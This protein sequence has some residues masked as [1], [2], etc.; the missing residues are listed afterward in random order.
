MA[1]SN[2]ERQKL[3][4]QKLKAQIA[5]P[6]RN[7]DELIE[8]IFRAYHSAYCRLHNPSFSNCMHYQEGVQSFRR[9][10]E[11]EL[12]INLGPWREPGKSS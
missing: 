9:S 8:A 3:H 12:G 2:A 1:L 5:N 11:K 6:L 4:R 7:D 10:I